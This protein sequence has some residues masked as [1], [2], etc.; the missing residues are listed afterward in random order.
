MPETAVADDWCK[1]AEAEGEAIAGDRPLRAARRRAR[2]S[3]REYELMAP[4]TV[5]VPEYTGH[6]LQSGE[7]LVYT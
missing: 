6:K 2:Q 7:A 1:G 5:K 3:I 4:R